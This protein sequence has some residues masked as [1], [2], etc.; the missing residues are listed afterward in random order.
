MKTK[1]DFQQAIADAIA[2]YPVAAQFYQAK[3]PRLLAKLDAMAAMLALKSAEGDVQSM[4]MFTKARDVTVLAE[5]SVKGILPF[6]QPTIARIQI[7]NVKD[8]DFS[9]VTG[10]KLQDTQGRE[11]SVIVG[12]TIPANSSAM[13]DAKQYSESSFT[14]VVSASQPFYQIPIPAREPGKHIVEIR[15]SNGSYDFEYSQDFVNVD[16]GKRVFH[17]ETDETRRMYVQFGH[18]GVAGYQPSVGETFTVTVMETE[19]AIDIQT[20]SNFAFEYSASL[21]EN[22]AVLQLD[23]ILSPGANPM[24]IATMREVISYPSIYDSSAVYLGNFDFLIR[25]NLS[26]FEFLSVW[27]EQTEEGVRGASLNNINRIFVAA[28]KEGVDTPTLRGQIEAVIRD[29]DDSYRVTHKDIIETEVALSIIAYIPAIYDAASVEQQIREIAL[30]EYGRDSAWSKRGRV[31]INHKK[32]SG[33]LEK[34]VQALQT[35]NSDLR[36]TTT[37]PGNDDGEERTGKSYTRVGT[38]VTVAFTAHGFVVGDSFPV[39]D[40]TDSG[41]NGNVVITAKTTDTFDFETTATGANGT[42]TLVAYPRPEKWR[43]VSEASLSVTI[44]QTTY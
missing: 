35:A 9:V 38:T 26:P 20:G 17:I 41:I 14:H 5:A 4:E 30:A 19:G 29:A 18:S 27:N 13:V 7:T 10:R 23:S 42:L 6:G 32:L 12:A 39:T 33:V 36:I 44:N 8:T 37:Y 22:G 43:F 16:V 25:R 21:Y 40:A 1:Q 11:Y 2:E 3:D 28:Q 24:D 31:K 34:N 15:V